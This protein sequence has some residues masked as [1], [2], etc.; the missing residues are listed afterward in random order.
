MTF[1]HSGSMQFSLL[2][3]QRDKILGVDDM[4]RGVLYDDGSRSVRMLSSSMAP[5]RSWRTLS[6]AA[7]GKDH[8]SVYMKGLQDACQPEPVQTLVYEHNEF[9]EDGPYTAYI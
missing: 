9:T 7:D 4:G 6:V 1:E 3:R 5:P 2:G 8:G